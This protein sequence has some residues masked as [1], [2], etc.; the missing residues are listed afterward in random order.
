M[1]SCDRSI[2]DGSPQ[3]LLLV[4]VLLVAECAVLLILRHSGV[5]VLMLLVGMLLLVS[6]LLVLLASGRG[7]GG[8]GA[9]MLTGKIDLGSIYKQEKQKADK[10][11]AGTRWGVVVVVG[12]YSGHSR[13]GCRQ[14]EPDAHQCRALAR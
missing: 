9:E 1:S 12:T 13:G 7:H 11:T 5:F 10:A 14:P 4:L 8:G 3:V 2:D 6:L